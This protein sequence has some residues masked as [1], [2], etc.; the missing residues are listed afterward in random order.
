LKIRRK[1]KEKRRKKGRKRFGEGG[2]G[3][4]FSCLILPII[5]LSPLPCWKGA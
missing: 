4:S 2:R 3:A 1:E 5:N